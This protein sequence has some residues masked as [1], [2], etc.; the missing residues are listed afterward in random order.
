MIQRNENTIF[1]MCHEELLQLNV[2]GV[3]HLLKSPS[4]DVFSEKH[5]ANTYLKAICIVCNNFLF[6]FFLAV[7]E[8][9]VPCIKQRSKSSS[10][11][12]VC[13]R[14]KKKTKKFHFEV[15]VAVLYIFIMTLCLFV[16]LQM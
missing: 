14:R 2:A 13:K 15:S 10:S 9:M 1:V 12:T 16:R 4:V 6:V 11:E 5:V 3:G 7:L 8:C